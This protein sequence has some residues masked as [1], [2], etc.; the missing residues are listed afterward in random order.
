MRKLLVISAV[1]FSVL[2]GT[3]FS[4]I[5]QSD[6]TLSEIRVIGTERI[7][8]A[9]VLTYSNLEAGDKANDTILNTVLGRLYA[10]NLFKDISLSLDGT[11][12]TIEVDENPIIN[13]ISIE[14]NRVLTDEQLLQVI[15]IRPRRVFTEK[16]AL[17]TKEILVEVYR[18]SG[19]YA[20]VIEPKIIELPNKR[21]DLVFE[22][23]EGPL[24]K[25]TSIRFIG[26]E[27][28][29]DRALKNVVQSR[30]AK[31]YV[32]FTGND[33]YDANRLSLD[34]QQLRQF[35]L[36]NGY[37]DI[38]VV[39][40]S[41]ELLADRS[42]FV[43]TIQLEEG[44][45]YSINEVVVRSA[46]EGVSGEELLEVSTLEQG[47]VYDIRILEETLSE[48]TN[49]LGEFG[50]AFVDVLPRIN[51]NQEQSTLDI[52]IEVGQAEKN[53]VEEINIKGN[54]RT[55]DRVIRREFELVEGDSFNQLKLTRSE[56]NVRNLGYFSDVSVSVLPGSSAE[57]SVVDLEVTETTTGSFSI[58][59]GY[60]TFDR[61]SF[62]FGIAENNF[63]GS[64]RNIRASADLSSRTTEFRAGITEPYLF[65]RNLAGSFDIFSYTQEYG[66]VEFRQDGLDLGASFSAAN[67]YRHRVGY[68]IANTESEISST[69]ATSVSGDD[70]KKLLSEISYSLT[71]DTRDSRID[72]REG[73]LLS[74]SESF[75]GLGGETTYLRTVLRGQ[76]LYPAYF[77]SIVI[78][79]DGEIGY[80]DGLG[81][82][83]SRSNRF[84]LGGRKL[85]GFGSAGIGPRD[86]GDRTAVGGNKYYVGSLNITSDIGFDKDLG[87][88]WT[89]FSDAG[90][91]WETDYPEGVHEPDNS[92]VRVSVGAGLLWDTAIGPMSF[93]WAVPVQKEDYDQEKFFQFQFGGRF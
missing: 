33:K 55:L 54:D 30:E 19:R 9:T 43:I 63:L 46:I 83:V 79:V 91:V 48:M 70:D 23:E 34:V 4:T 21:V 50:Y 74:L 44:N 13:R 82:K 32:I 84:I 15:N 8:P 71:K 57:Q 89:I 52:A 56:R 17:D 20:A 11:V 24:I 72:P 27:A 59:L 45:Q 80:I 3:S 49:R 68:L 5:A 37:A 76:Y 7:D 73:Y 77:K 81:E 14:G 78:G 42:G 53:Y 66:S 58:G 87:M 6:E 38:D 67:N 69:T 39:H 29:S 75:A 90:S 64:G 60:S 41:G 36:Q 26:N 25:I 61:T 22:V 65:G 35:Y 92:N 40:A 28:F 47:D 31:W 86:I 51:L 12:L 2:A 88:R 62:K 85:R 10:T 18:Q 16:L 93:L 1:L